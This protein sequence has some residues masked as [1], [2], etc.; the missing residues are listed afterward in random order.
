MKKYKETVFSTL[1]SSPGCYIHSLSISLIS[2]VSALKGSTTEGI[3]PKLVEHMR[4]QMST[5]GAMN[6]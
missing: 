4:K 1:E 6:Y 5:M 3:R 2:L